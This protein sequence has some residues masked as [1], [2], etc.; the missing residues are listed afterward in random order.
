MKMFRNV[1]GFSLRGKYQ[2]VRVEF[3]IIDGARHAAIYESKESPI[4][5]TYIQ[6]L[7]DSDLY[8]VAYKFASM[9]ARYE[10]HPHG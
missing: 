4:Y 2:H 6:P 3:V 8:R 1:N 9:C 5:P 7:H 10:F